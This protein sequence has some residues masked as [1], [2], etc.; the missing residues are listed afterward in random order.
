M[1]GL[2][3]PIDCHIDVMRVD[4][5]NGK[6]GYLHT[7]PEYG[8][9]RLLAAGSGDCFQLGH[10]FRQGEYGKRHNP[11]FTMLEWYRV[12][13][14]YQ[15]FIEETLDLIRLELGPLPASFL[16]Y[17]EALQKFTGIDYITAT[18]EDLVACAL[19]HGQHLSKDAIH[20]DRDTLLA[21]LLGCVVEPHLGIDELLV[22]HDYPASQAAL[23]RTRQTSDGI[24]AER[25]EIY[26]QGVELANGYHE[27]TD[28]V[29]QRNR[30][31]KEE[32]ERLRRGKPPLVI[33]EQFLAALEAG[34]PP[35]CG[36]AVGFDRLLMLRLNKSAL[37]DVLPLIEC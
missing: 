34:L 15:I 36:V 19:S 9:K 2:A 25:F 29:E 33:D 30:L 31:E 26:Y 17:R 5:G 11:E 24:V 20:W 3:A 18:P 16:T 21:V 23:A 1:L 6:W 37:T 10:V 13:M 27:L 14:P 32:Q 7:S 22:L 4:I 28:A 8:M 12:G 35:C